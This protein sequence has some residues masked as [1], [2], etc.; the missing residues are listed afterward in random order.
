[1]SRLQNSFV[2]NPDSKNSP[3][4]SQKACIE[5]L[6]TC[7]LILICHAGFQAS[8]KLL[9]KTWENIF[10]LNLILDTKWLKCIILHMCF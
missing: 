2:P 4:G 9:E 3:F 1:M 10:F 5:H 8:W 7:Y 6:K